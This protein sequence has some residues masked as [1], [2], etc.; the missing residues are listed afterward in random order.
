MKREVD[1]TEFMVWITDLLHASLGV[2]GRSA[3]NQRVRFAGL[4]LL[5]SRGALVRDRLQSLPPQSVLLALVQDTTLTIE[6][7]KEECN[8]TNVK[9]IVLHA[10]LSFFLRDP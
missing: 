6:T 3:G 1:N 10:T 7:K 9:Q 8:C 5:F 2:D 4:F